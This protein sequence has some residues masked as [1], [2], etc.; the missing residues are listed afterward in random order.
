M[1]SRSW[2]I[3][4]SR[5]RTSRASFLSLLEAERRLLRVAAVPRFVLKVCCG[6][7]GLRLVFRRRLTL[8]SPWADDLNL[9]QQQVGC[10]AQQISARN[11]EV[12]QRF[13]ECQRLTRAPERRQAHPVPAAPGTDWNSARPFSA[14]DVRGSQ[15][16]LA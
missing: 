13:R 12:E 14:I 6:F 4:S 10:A 9:T 2:S 3:G 8:S 1:T 15:A 16:D 5:S 7:A 11:T